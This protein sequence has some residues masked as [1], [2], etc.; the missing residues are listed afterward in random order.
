MKAACVILRPC[1]SL[2]A[3]RANS[4]QL[5]NL[6][7]YLGILSAHIRIWGE[8]VL[9]NCIGSGSTAIAAIRENRHFIG[10][11]LDDKYYKIATE[12]VSKELQEPKIR[13]D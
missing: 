6:L 2:S 10:M 5:K 9:D 11:E 8:V 13:F 3:T 1:N 7:N 4:T 12:R